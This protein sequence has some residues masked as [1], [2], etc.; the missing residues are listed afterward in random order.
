MSNITIPKKEYQQL[1]EIKFRYENLRNFFVQDIFASPS[2]KKA[3]D[4]IKEF[5]KTKLYNQAFI[6]SLEKGLKR[7]SYF[8]NHENCIKTF[9]CSYNLI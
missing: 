8:N 6:N 4:I 7:S 5:K 9:Q 2:I 3:S 1:V